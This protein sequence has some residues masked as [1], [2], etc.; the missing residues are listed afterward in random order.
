[1]R[2]VLIIFFA[3]NLAL[4]QEA[5]HNYGSMQIHG[6]TMVG[7]HMDLINDGAF[8][9][10]S[11]L[12]GF[13]SSNKELTL[14]GN[15]NPVFYDAEVA[16]DNGF[17]I[18][19][20]MGVT[21]N[22]NL[23]SGIIYTPRTQSEVNLSFLTDS[24]YVGESDNTLIDGY[25]SIQGKDTFTFP[26]GEDNV[27][28]PLTITSQSINDYAKSAYYRE[29]PNSPS[30]FGTSFNTDQTA[31]EYI[32]VSDYE[33]WHLE[34]ELPSKVTLTWNEESYVSL[35]GDFISDLKVV[36]WNIENKEW[37]NLGNTDVQG[38]M[39]NG[40]ITSDTFIP[41]DYE[42]ITIGGNNDI[43][44]TLNSVE[45]DNYYMTPNGD[46]INDR[47]VIDAVESSPNNSLQIFNRYGI[48]VYSKENYNNEFNGISNRESAIAKNSG[49][50]SG[51]YFYIITLNDLNIRHQGYLYLTTYQNN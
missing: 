30:I 20:T 35:L 50:A 3:F 40:S 31:N 7:F 19:N 15:S 42:I 45:L 18:E 11:G 13:Y 34:G 44:E 47:L 37:E 33:F 2:F 26:I 22:L 25:A 29:S 21:N 16:V 43:L 23:I 28:R 39:D 17:Y 6:S 12:V 9:Q 48:L 36:G 27:L 41:N 38:D 5:V 32:A 46:G 10:N 1:M 49:L 24:F 4:A 8:N 14:S 51:I